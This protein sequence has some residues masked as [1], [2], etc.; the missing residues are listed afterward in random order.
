MWR[1]RPARVSSAEL[2]LAPDRACISLIRA[3]SLCSLG[4]PFDFAQGRLRPPLHERGC[5]LIAT[6]ESDS[7]E[8]TSKFKLSFA[9]GSKSNA[10]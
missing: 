6:Q 10:K 5:F 9:C 3:R 4:G 1:G 8:L 2:L 7:G